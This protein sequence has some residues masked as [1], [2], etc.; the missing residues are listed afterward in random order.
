M[1]SPRFASKPL[2]Q[3]AVSETVEAAKPTPL[4][5]QMYRCALNQAVYRSK[6]FVCCGAPLQTFVTTPH[7]FVPRRWVV[8]SIHVAAHHRHQLNRRG[9]VHELEK[10]AS[11]DIDAYSDEFVAPLRHDNPL[12]AGTRN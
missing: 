9:E 10:V 12:L 6:L 4:A 8:P 3:N 1:Y 5:M 11:A 2:A 7:D